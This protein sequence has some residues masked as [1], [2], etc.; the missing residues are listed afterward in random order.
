MEKRTLVKTDKNGTK[1]WNTRVICDHCG[2]GTGIY[3][4]GA[5]QTDGHGHVIGSTYAGTCFKCGGAGYVWEIVK[6]Y[7]PEYRA[8]LDAANERRKA[9]Q[10]AK[11]EAA[12][13]EREKAWAEQR[14]KEA[15]ERE[16]R[17][18]AEEARKA[19]SQHVGNVGERL[20]LDVTL[21]RR[22]SYEVRSYMGYGTETRRIYI[23]VDA[24]GNKFAWKTS[25][26][27]WR[28]A[29][30]T[31]GSVQEGEQVCIKC[32]VKAHGEFNGEKQ[33]EIQRVKVAEKKGV[34]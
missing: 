30:K 23:F 8:K 9:K 22:I 4:W 19:I 17:R 32:T 1:Y 10:R 16:A 26:F 3:K 11:W 34:A 27:L 15:A 6:E 5:I 14:A 33:T 31:E 18:K 29:A 13:A 25:G 24:A 21:E 20:T 2:D 28:D 12:R 7:T